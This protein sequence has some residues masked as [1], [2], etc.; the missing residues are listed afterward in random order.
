MVGSLLGVDYGCLPNGSVSYEVIAR[1]RRA[2]NRRIELRIKPD[3]VRTNWNRAANLDQT[4]LALLSRFGSLRGV[5]AASEAEIAALPGF[6]A[7]L[8]RK[9]KEAVAAVGSA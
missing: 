3:Y 1:R 7:A 9:V 6:G 2:S 8:A 4:K 5:A